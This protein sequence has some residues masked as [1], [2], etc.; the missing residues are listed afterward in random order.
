M[1]DELKEDNNQFRIRIAFIGI[2]LSL[3][4]F[5]SGGMTTIIWKMS[6]YQTEI[7]YLRDAVKDVAKKVEANHID[8]SGKIERAA[9]DRYRRVDAEKDLNAIYKLFE[10]RARQIED[11]KS[12]VSNLEILQKK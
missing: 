12:R 7:G 10:D 4:I 9:D 6:S 2:I 3:F 5:L 11:L 1:K 8:L